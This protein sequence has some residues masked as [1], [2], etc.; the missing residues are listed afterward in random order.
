MSWYYNGASYKAAITKILKEQGHKFLTSSDLGTIID[1]EYPFL[2]ASPDQVIYCKCCG[3]GL[4]EIKCPY[5][6]RNVS[7]STDILQQIDQKTLNL[8]KNHDHYYQI[9]GQLGI[10]KSLH[11]WYFVYTDHGYYIEKILFDQDFYNDIV[12]NLKTFWFNFMARELLYNNYL[13]SVES[14][15]ISSNVDPNLSSHKVR[16]TSE[17]LVSITLPT[18]NKIINKRRLKKKC[19]R[20]SK[21]T[22]ACCYTESC[23]CVS[24]MSQKYSIYCRHF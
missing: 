24:I 1:K 2:S 3:N 23:F 22:K 16:Q 8:K 15:S 7:P 21:S 10:H 19:K 14:T 11:C 17:S 12:Q 9:Q 20:E 6:I 5:S 4:V 13:N 18:E